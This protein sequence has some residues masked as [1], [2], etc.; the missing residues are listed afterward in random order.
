VLRTACKRQRKQSIPESGG[1]GSWGWDTA[2]HRAC[3]DGTSK[4][5]ALEMPACDAARGTK[6]RSRHRGC[7][8]LLAVTLHAAQ[9]L[10][11]LTPATT[12]TAA[13][14]VTRALCEMGQRE[15]G[16][17]CVKYHACTGVGFWQ[18]ARCEPEQGGGA[19]LSAEP[20]GT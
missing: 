2:S 3:R 13:C 14:C 19:G 15:S 8:L 18:W 4:V 11:C 5:V 12:H 20:V 16:A 7:H 10:S 1:C 17:T 6:G 9:R